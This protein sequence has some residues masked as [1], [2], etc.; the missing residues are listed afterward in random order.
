M[1]QY[2]VCILVHMKHKRHLKGMYYQGMLQDN[3]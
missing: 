3:C 1:H 2:I